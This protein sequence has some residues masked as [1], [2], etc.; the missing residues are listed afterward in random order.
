ML[1]ALSWAGAISPFSP[2]RPATVAC[3][4]EA[5]LEYVQVA[6]MFLHVWCRFACSVGAY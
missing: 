2:P 3:K 4:M 1:L 6:Y 5:Q